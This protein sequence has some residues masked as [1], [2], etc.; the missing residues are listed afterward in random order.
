[1]WGD[2][3]V[4]T[5]VSC[6]QPKNCQKPGVWPGTDLLWCLQRERGPATALMLNVYPPRLQD[7]LLLFKSGLS[8]C[9]DLV[10]D[11]L[12]RSWSNNR[13][14]VHNNCNALESSP[15]HPPVCMCMRTRAHT[16]THTHTHTHSGP[17]K[18]HLPQNQFLVPRLGSAGLSHSVYGSWF[19]GS[20]RK[21][22]KSCTLLWSLPWRIPTNSLDQFLLK[23]RSFISSFRSASVFLPSRVLFHKCEWP[24]AVQF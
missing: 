4:K 10:P 5:G 24:L 14:K 8:S 6:F 2:S 23:F 22:T 9:Q 12:K 15:N 7:K 21:L 11:G 13:N 19:H 17:W 3:H 20:P 18:N 1:M 16:H